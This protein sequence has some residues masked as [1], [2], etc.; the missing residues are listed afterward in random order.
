LAF[1]RPYESHE[2]PTTRASSQFHPSRRYANLT[3]T[4]PCAASLRT[5]SIVN[6][7]LKKS[8]ER[9]ELRAV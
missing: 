1:S 6:A 2:P 5:I 4:T 8:C 9:E 3:R 7:M